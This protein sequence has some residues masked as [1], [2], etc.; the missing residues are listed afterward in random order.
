MKFKNY[1][2]PHTKDSRIYSDNDIYN[3]TLGNIFKN[4]KEILGQKRAIGIPSVNELKSSGNVVWISEYTRDDGTRVCGHWRSKPDGIIGD[5]LAIA[6]KK[7]HK[8]ETTTGGAAKIDRKKEEVIINK[9]PKNNDIFFEKERNKP[10]SILMRIN[11]E[12]NAERPDAKLLMDIALV[13]PEKVPSTQDYQV[14]GKENSKIMNEKYRLT[15]TNKEIPE[16]YYGVEFRADS[17]TAQRLNNSTELKNEIFNEQKNYDSKT[18]KFK[19]DKLEIEFKKDKNLQYSFGHMTILNPKIENG[20]VTGL[21]F[22][23]YD[24][25]LFYVEYFKDIKTTTLNNSA[26]FWQSIGHLKNYFIF[27]PIKIK[28]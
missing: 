19:S 24:F 26:K 11:A 12:K 6:N 3:M 7:F 13:N 4:A 9:L 14:A 15:G 16:H 20:Y 21:A 1:K 18:G 2:N 22:D 5:N 27:V 25:D 17:P 10:Q 28:I 23:K 8:S